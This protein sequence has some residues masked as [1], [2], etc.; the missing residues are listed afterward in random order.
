MQLCAEHGVLLSFLSENGE[1]LARVQGQVAGNVLLRR[2][3][4]RWADSAERSAGVSRAL[5]AGKVANCRTLMLRSARE[6]DGG[7]EAAILRG[8]AGELGRL[9]D[10][11][12]RCHVVASLR[13]REGEAGRIYFGAFDALIT[14]EDEEF[15]FRG[16]SRRPPLDAVNAL[17][18]F[19]YTLVAHDVTAALESVG[20]DPYVGFLHEDRPGRPGLALDLMEEFRPALGDRLALALLNRRQVRPSGFR[21]TESGA[22]MMDDATRKE[23]L[24]AYQ[25]RKQTEVEHPFLEERLPI[26]LLPH[27]QALLLARHIRG[28][29]DAYPPYVFR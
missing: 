25:Q 21:K 2:A 14:A 1:F 7:G 22:V 11:L 15:R 27:A 20:L 18:S 24:V 19:L 28:D 5:V 16:R 23:V 8:A 10:G 13:G 12:E 29:I 17:L 9:V 4:H 26:G 3:Q 6:R